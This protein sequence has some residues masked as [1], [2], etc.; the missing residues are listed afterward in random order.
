MK[1]VILPLS[2]VLLYIINLYASEIIHSNELRAESEGIS[3]NY[4]TLHQLLLPPPTE[5]RRYSVRRIPASPD[6]LKGTFTLILYGGNHIN[7]LET[8]A[9]LDIEGDNFYFEPY[10][11]AFLYKIRKGLSSEKALEDSI[12]FISWHNSFYKYELSKIPRSDGVILGY[13]VRPLY[14]PISFGTSDVLDVDYFIEGNKIKTIIKLIPSVE[15]LL[16]DGDG[17]VFGE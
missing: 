3:E 16:L 15:R 8:I 7:D 14:Y 2:I 17:K 10:A 6:E 4:N 13:E 11:P 12:N 9:I 5:S 1:K